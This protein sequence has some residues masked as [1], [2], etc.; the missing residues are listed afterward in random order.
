[1]SIEEQIELL[2]ARINC[3]NKNYSLVNVEA[4][5]A[6]SLAIPLLNELNRKKLISDINDEYETLN[7]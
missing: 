5:A 2:N 4:L 7:P 3:V 6:L 1:M